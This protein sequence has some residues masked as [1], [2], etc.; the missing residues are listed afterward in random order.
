MAVLLHARVLGAAA[1]RP[2]VADAALVKDRFQ[3][4]SAQPESAVDN[5]GQGRVALARVREVGDHRLPIWQR[6]RRHR[7][8]CLP[9]QRRRG[10]VAVVDKVD[11]AVVAVVGTAD[12]VLAT[13]SGDA[14]D[15]AAAL[16]ARLVVRVGR[17]GVVGNP[18]VRSALSTRRC[19]HRT[20]SV[21][22]VCLTAGEQRF[23]CVKGPRC[24]IWQ[25]RLAPRRRTWCRPCSIS[26]RW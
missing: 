24:L 21:V 9:K 5:L 13:V 6:I 14:A 25:K 4:V 3:A 18:S 26:V 19:T 1:H 22:F 2:E 7:R 20:S 15:V 23:A 8:R 17:Q 16:R 11:Q 12:R 10:V